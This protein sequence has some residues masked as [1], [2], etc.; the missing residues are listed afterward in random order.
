M[1]RFWLAHGAP[2]RRERASLPTA[3]NRLLS[4]IN[5]LADR[6]QKKRF[7]SGVEGSRCGV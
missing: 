7:T 2:R 4:N 1:S 6:A 3:K 5:L